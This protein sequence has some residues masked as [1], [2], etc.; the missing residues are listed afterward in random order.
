MLH[1]G[2]LVERAIGAVELVDPHKDALSQLDLP[3][4]G[5]GRLL[6][7]P[8]EE[9]GFNRSHGSPQAV[10][11]CDEV[12][13][14]SLER[15]G[16]VLDI[17]A[18][19]QGVYGPGH[20]RF[21]GQQLL[22]TKGQQR[23]LLGGQSQRLIVGVGVQAL[24]SPQHRRQGLVGRA[25]HVGERLLSGE[26]TPAGLGVE[27]QH[28]ALGVFG[29][30]LLPHDPGPHPPGRAKFRRLLEDIPMGREEK[31]QP[32]P[33]G[34]HIQP[35]IHGRL[36]VG[37]TVGQGKGD[38]LGRGASGLADVVSRDADGVP[39]GHPLGT[40]SEQVGDEPH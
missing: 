33:K 13:G 34:I 27:A 23:A 31:G 36:H 9:P 28:P 16:Q 19:P 4:K 6:D 38:L 15:I 30:E 24:G 18:T 2:V 39:L 10:N 29:P 21:I 5:P 20:P 7:L 25:H 32:R 11:L 17:E 40:K 1:R 14:F 12:R 8:L 35:G 26:G 22:S 3:L 37:L